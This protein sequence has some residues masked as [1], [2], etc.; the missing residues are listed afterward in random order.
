MPLCRRCKGEMGQTAAVCPHC[1]FDFPDG[2]KTDW[3]LW[4]HIGRPG[5]TGASRNRTRA[6]R[7]F[8]AGLLLDSLCLVDALFVRDWAFLWALAPLTVGCLWSLLAVRWIDIY[9][10]RPEVGL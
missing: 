9:D 10:R 6:M 3:P 4:V 2:R 1:G 8:W 5:I 7:L